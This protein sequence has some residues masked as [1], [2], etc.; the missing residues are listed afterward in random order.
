[1]WKILQQPLL[2]IIFFQ[3]AHVLSMWEF[4]F[5]EP[6]R[7]GSKNNATRR[8]HERILFCVV[9]AA[10]AVTASSSVFLF[11]VS[12]TSGMLSVLQRHH[13]NVGLL[14]VTIPFRCWILLQSTTE[15]AFIT[16][17]SI[18][19]TVW[20]AD[21]GTIHR[22]FDIQPI[23]VPKWI[24][25]ISPKKSM[26]GF[27]GGI[28]GGVWTSTSWI[29]SIVRWTKLDTSS[30]FQTIWLTSPLW[31]RLAFGF[32]L[33]ILAIVGDLVE[34]SIKRQSQSKDSGSVLP[35]HGGILDRFDSSLLA[36]LFYQ[37]TKEWTSR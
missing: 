15:D 28:V 25:L 30:S 21:T 26:E 10:L 22:T 34:S 1:M 12:L 16:T 36:I 5:L 20:N 9:S 32:T 18:L 29:P 3:G 11:L 6:I 2:A 19:L 23:R 37:A 31:Q 8:H 14:L 17:I 13:Y 4:T 7:A 35:G 33:S 24:H 27:I